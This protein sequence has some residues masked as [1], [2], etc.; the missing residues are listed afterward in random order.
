MTQYCPVKFLGT[1]VLKSDACN[2]D[3]GYYR[4]TVSRMVYD[5]RR[6]IVMEYKTADRAR[7]VIA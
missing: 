6:P 3:A 7:P 4:A 5:L 1:M 2:D